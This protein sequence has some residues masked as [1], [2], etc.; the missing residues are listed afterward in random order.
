MYDASITVPID[1]QIAFPEAGVIRVVSEILFAEPDQERCRHFLNCVLL[2]PE[3]ESV[4][5]APATTPMMELRFD[6]RRHDRKSVLQ[7]IAELIGA[8]NSAANHKALA[9]AP[10]STARDRHGVV[11]YQRYGRHVTGWR[12]ERERLGSLRLSNPVLYRKGAL[13][14]A[15]E[16]EL[17]SVLGVNRYDTSSVNCRVD[18]EYD[19]RQLNTAQLI[20]I[21]DGTL[22]GTEHPDRLDKLDLDLTICTISLPVAAAAQFAVP[23]L[24]PVAGALLLYTTLTS[25][26]ARGAW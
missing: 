6:S 2:A 16:R 26:K 7:R 15:I 23:A 4:S 3:I 19:P 21:L 20:E 13:C 14:Q 5:I 1:A 8:G 9:I 11:R 22:A 17:M 12:V 24:L 18:I 25:F 10:A